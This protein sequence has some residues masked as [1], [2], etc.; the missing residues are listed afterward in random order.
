MRTHPFLE[1]SALGY[2]HLGRC[3]RITFA[4]PCSGRW[5]ATREGVDRFKHRREFSSDEQTRHA[6][7]LRI[8]AVGRM[9]N[10][11]FVD[12]RTSEMSDKD[13]WKASAGW[14]GRSD[15]IADAG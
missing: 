7:G 14:E 3:E 1:W 2:S 15:Q 4:T 8:H 13:G 10:H 9:L 11:V 12:Q 5:H 6:F